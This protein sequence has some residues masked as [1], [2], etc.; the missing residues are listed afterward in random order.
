MPAPISSNIR[1]QMIMVMSATIPMAHNAAAAMRVPTVRYPTLCQDQCGGR[2]QA[3]A[4]LEAFAE[5][6][7]GVLFRYLLEARPP[8]ADSRPGSSCLSRLSCRSPE[9]SFS[10]AVEV[11]LSVDKRYR[12]PATDSP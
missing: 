3:L 1:T 6:H 12:I 4:L 7:G 5:R 2:S 9:H 10:A 8:S 11:T